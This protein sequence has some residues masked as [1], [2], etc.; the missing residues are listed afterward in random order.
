MKAKNVSVNV[1]INPL[2]V[3]LI[4]KASKETQR[5]RS[6]IIRMI[7]QLYFEMVEQGKIEPIK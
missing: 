4:D 7:L 2:I 1:L 5:N 6:Q 3:E